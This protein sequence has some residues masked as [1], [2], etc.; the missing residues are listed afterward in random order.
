MDRTKERSYR[1]LHGCLLFLHEEKFRV[2]NRTLFFANGTSTL[3][4]AS[5]ILVQTAAIQAL[6]IEPQGEEV[7]HE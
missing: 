1:A 5:S 2:A 4:S 6:E 3:K 7:R